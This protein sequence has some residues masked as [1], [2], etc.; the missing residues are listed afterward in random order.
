MPAFVHGLDRAD[1]LA[2]QDCGLE[3]QS[4]G[5]RFFLRAEH[6]FKDASSVVH[7]ATKDLVCAII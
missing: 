1:S 2:K 3:A 5:E 4:A 6:P 7:V